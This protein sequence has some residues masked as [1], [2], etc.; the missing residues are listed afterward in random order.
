MRIIIII[1]FIIIICLIC[2]IMWKI[3]N[4]K[5]TYRTVFIFSTLLAIV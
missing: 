5:S 3:F 2:Y 1:I 4:L